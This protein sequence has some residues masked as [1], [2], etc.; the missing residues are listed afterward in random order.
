MTHCLEY[1]GLY[2][3]NMIDI[4]WSALATIGA[5]W[6]LF[7]HVY[8]KKLPIFDFSGKIPRPKPIESMVFFGLFFNIFRIINASILITDI[9]RN[10]I[11]RAVLFEI[12]WQFGMT[13]L[14][15]Y[16][17]GV[18]HTLANSS[19]HLYNSWVGSQSAV[20]IVGFVVIA[21]PIIVINIISI[22]A[23]YYA[24]IGDVNNATI[25]TEAIY[26][27][28]GAFDFIIGSMIL[29]SGLRLLRLL[30]GHL[31]SQGNLRENIVKIK[32]GATKVKIIIVIGC[33]C[34][35]GYCAVITIYASSRY[36]IMLDTPYTIVITS[37]TL[38]NGP[39]ATCIIEFAIILNIKLLNGISNLSIGSID[40][41]DSDNT[42]Y[43][44]QQPQKETFNTN[45]SMDDHHRHSFSFSNKLQGEN[46]WS[47]R[48]TLACQQDND[49]GGQ[50]RINNINNKKCSPDNLSSP[51]STYSFHHHQHEE[52]D[53]SFIHL[54]SIQQHHHQ[55]NG[56]KSNES[57]IEEDQRHYNA[58]TSQFRMPSH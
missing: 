35:W 49:D 8:L 57:S 39:L 50:Y 15:C 58:M 21:L 33:A 5:L 18:C 4:V 27:S 19:R 10:A 43:T 9:G 32:L 23:G 16:F 20:D 7:D 44:S 14:S 3:V 34:L 47:R 25:W 45:I 56:K 13:A 2:I 28:W 51:S 12:P 22:V 36:Y 42:V 48:D 37:I 26:Y 6:I 11:L 46:L 38:F 30:K 52:D 31:L 41:F 54:Q 40:E 55:D 17:F 29:I 53:G 1:D 24:Q